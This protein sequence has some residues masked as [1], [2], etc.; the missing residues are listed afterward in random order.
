LQ[1][2][3]NL[4]NNPMKK[5]TLAATLLILIIALASQPVGADLSWSVLKEL[6]LEGQPL[7]VATSADGQTLFILV[8]G[9]IHVF[10]VPENAISKKIPVEKGFNRIA[11]APALHA[12]VVT[13]GESKALQILKLQDIHQLDLSGLPFRGPENAPVT[14]VVFSGYQ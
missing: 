8:S 1:N 13:G 9:E 4:R 11:Y 6:N 7:D 12:L 2:N 10:S 14:V 5:S 3:P